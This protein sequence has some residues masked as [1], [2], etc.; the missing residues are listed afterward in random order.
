M[1]ARTIEVV[2][3]DGKIWALI[4]MITNFKRSL[5]DVADDRYRMIKVLQMNV[6]ELDARTIATPAPTILMKISNAHTKILCQI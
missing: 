6:I 4:G 1:D 2:S 3:H 5:D